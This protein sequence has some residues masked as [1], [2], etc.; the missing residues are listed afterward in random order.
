MSGVKSSLT[1]AAY[2]AAGGVVLDFAY[3]FVSPYIPASITGINPYMPNVLKIAGAF[4]IGALAK[5]AV[6]SEKAGAVLAGALAIQL[7]NLM[8]S[9]LGGTAGMAGLGA[10]MNPGGRATGGFGALGAAN[11]APFLGGPRMGRI[12][13]MGAYMAPAA[14]IQPNMAG[15]DGYGN[16]NF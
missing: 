16:N 6:G 2:G 14:V 10:Y 3:N 7:Y 1:Y 13:R 12:G 5:S 11:P 15:L 9:L 4:G 8:A